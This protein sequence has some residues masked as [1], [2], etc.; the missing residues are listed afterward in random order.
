MLEVKNVTIKIQEKVIIKNL[1]FN[2]HSGDCLA[3]IGEEG[4]GKT[5]LLKA[6]IGQL[7]LQWIDGQIVCRAKRIGYLKQ[8]LEEDLANSVF[9][10]LY[11]SQDDYYRK[12]N[13]YYKLIKDLHLREDIQEVSSISVL[14]GGEKVK[15]QLL[16]IL[17]QEPD[18]LIFDEPTN[19]L[20]LSTLLWLEQFIKKQKIPIIYVSHDERLLTA[21]AN[22]ILHLEMIH[23]KSEPRWT[24]KK[25]GYNEYIN[26]RDRYLK[27]ATMV[28]KKEQHLYQKK[29][30]KLDRIT[31]K[32]EHAQNVISRRYPGEAAK[33]KKKIHS[34][35][36]QEKRMQNQSISEKPMVEDAI[37]FQ[38][39]PVLLPQRKEILKL[40]LPVLK[41]DNKVLSRNLHL[42]ILGNKH[43]VIVGKNG[44]GKTTL[45]KFILHQLQLRS[46]LKVG[47]MPQNYDELWNPMDTPLDFLN[48]DFNNEEIGK[49]RSYLGNMNFSKEEM[50]TN[51]KYLSG[52]TKAKLIFLKFVLDGCNVL[53][54]DEPTRN[55]SP[56]SIPVICQMLQ[57]YGGAIISISHDRNFIEQVCQE[58]YELSKEGLKRIY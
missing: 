5:T 16:K 51:M 6:L 9:D 48:V 1:S 30:E 41:I 26:A 37:F 33:L 36:A 25:M 40:D 15:L 43:I 2:L 19:D 27:H 58:K 11:E 46:D 57:S 42:H 35:K 21:T 12:I 56:L 34:L 14:S 47:Y 50:T 17:L 55:V 8:N 32:V 39:N 49:V 52:G 18:L 53:L 44:V 29:K 24:Y 10:Y 3:I 38:F 54:L 13:L 20:D 31:Q 23:N 7:E 28:A 22:Q 4:T 45:L